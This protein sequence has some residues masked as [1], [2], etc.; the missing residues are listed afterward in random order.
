MIYSIDER[1]DPTMKSDVIQVSLSLVDGRHEKDRCCL[2]DAIFGIGETLSQEVSW[3]I[4]L[5]LVRWEDLPRLVVTLELV[6]LRKLELAALR[7][8]IG[9]ALN[10]RCEY[11]RVLRGKGS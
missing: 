10:I 5:R 8:D 9:N 7:N 6:V 3:F 2:R 4:L 1:V 11:G